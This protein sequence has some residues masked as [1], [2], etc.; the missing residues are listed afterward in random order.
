MPMKAMSSPK[1][2]IPE[3]DFEKFSN[4]CDPSLQSNPDLARDLTCGAEAF[5]QAH[6][7]HAC[8]SWKQEAPTPTSYRKNNIPIAEQPATAKIKSATSS[9][10]G[11]GECLVLSILGNVWATPMG[12]AS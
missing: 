12:N 11:I 8:I 2:P 7:E 6:D 10:T 1:L 4:R 5:R 9:P 3:N